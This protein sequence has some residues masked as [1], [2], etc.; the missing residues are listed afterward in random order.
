M[1]DEAQ[2]VASPVDGDQ[3]VPET[4]NGTSAKAETPVVDSEKKTD[5]DVDLLIK[6]REEARREAQKLR[7]SLRKKEEAEA[8]AQRASLSEAERLLAEL[9]DLRKARQEWNNEKRQM[10][11]EGVA[12]DVA[13]SLG[14]IDYKDAL[15]LIPRSS[16]EYDDDGTPLNLRELFSNLVKSKPYLVAGGGQSAKVVSTNAASGTSGGAAPTLTAAELEAAQRAGISP[17]RWEALKA[18]KT[19]DDWKKTKTS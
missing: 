9:E 13:G 17:E 5:V 12:R 16:I 18:V 19:L 1:T 7:A 14:L 10:L 4:S 11:A 6:E 3:Q 15:A 8:E 2:Q